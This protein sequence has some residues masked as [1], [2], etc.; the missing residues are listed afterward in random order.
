MEDGWLIRTDH[1]LVRTNHS[2]EAAA[3]LAVR[4]ERLHQVWRQLF[5]GFYLS[6]RE[7]RELFA[8]RR[9]PRRQAQPMRVLYHRNKNE[10]VTALAKR[11]PRIAETIGIYF[12]AEKEAHFFASDAANDAQTMAT[13]YHEAAHQLFQECRPSA[14]H[15]GALANFW[16]IEG[17]ATYFETLVEHNDRIA[18][19]Y[20]TIGEANRGRTPAARARLLTDNFYV[21]LAELSSWGKDDLQR[22]PELAKIYSQ[23]AGLAA[24]LMD[25][26]EGRYREPLV[27]FL[28]V[29]YAGRDNAR[30]LAT[31]AGVSLEEL[32]AA[33]RR[34]LERLP[35]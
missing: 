27:R 12:D 15:V 7:V 1:F 11:Q 20:Y 32:D 30:T 35:E 6:E 26:D 23:S 4:L 19:L 31:A 3:E 5:A 25:G 17:V 2:L 21:P 10:Y 16:I 13:L 22:Q 18:G 28:N 34:Y 33:Y 14:R 8:G 29:V 9:L 24:F